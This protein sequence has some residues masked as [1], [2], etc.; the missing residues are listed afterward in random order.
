[1]RQ[2]H[3]ESVQA[4]FQDVLSN[5]Q[6]ARQFNAQFILKMSDL[7]GTDGT[8]GSNGVYPGANGDFTGAV[9][10]HWDISD[11]LIYP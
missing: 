10:G 1:L 3:G 7:W 5:F 4:R 8:Q 11:Q 9:F 2:T 6:T